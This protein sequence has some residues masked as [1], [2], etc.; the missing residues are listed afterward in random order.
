M[1]LAT[2]SVRPEDVA[3]FFQQQGDDEYGTETTSVS[4]LSLSLSTNNFVPY[5]TPRD[6]NVGAPNGA[7]TVHERN[8]TSG[9]VA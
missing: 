5:C 4:T 1:E 9:A 8:R 3:G 6:D 2:Q 7:E